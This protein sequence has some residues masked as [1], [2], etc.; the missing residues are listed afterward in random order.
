VIEQGLPSANGTSSTEVRTN[1]CVGTDEEMHMRESRGNVVGPCT[2]LERDGQDL[3]KAAFTRALGAI[4]LDG[5][6]M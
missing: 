5:G 2:G 6:G 3:L 1:H 4:N